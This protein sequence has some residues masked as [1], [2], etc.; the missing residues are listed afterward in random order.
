MVLI[1]GGNAPTICISDL[2]LH[3]RPMDII[4]NHEREIAESLLGLY[5]SNQFFPS[6]LR[7]HR[8][9]A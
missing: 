8:V 1:I 7:H 4:A 2:S 3:G 6:D 9:K 5:C